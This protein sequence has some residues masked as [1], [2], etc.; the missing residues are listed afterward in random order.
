MAEEKQI[1]G[2]LDYKKIK[3]TISEWLT[4]DGYTIE[5]INTVIEQN[6]STQ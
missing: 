2:Y 1:F 6:F 4:K 5:M 3:D